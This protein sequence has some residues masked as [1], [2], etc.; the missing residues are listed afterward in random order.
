VGV[1]SLLYLQDHSAM[2]SFGMVWCRSYEQRSLQVRSTAP[3]IYWDVNPLPNAGFNSMQG[4]SLRA[5][6]Y[7]RSLAINTTVTQPTTLTSASFS[8]SPFS[9]RRHSKRT[10]ERFVAVVKSPWL[11]GSAKL[12]SVPPLRW[13]SRTKPWGIMTRCFGLTAGYS[14]RLASGR[15]KCC[16]QTNPA[17]ICPPLRSC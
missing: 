2:I 15:E 14:G 5:I 4:N 1:K 7:F 16:C 8:Q 12:Q 3:L 10:T 9:G 13:T 11:S 6:K 17:Q